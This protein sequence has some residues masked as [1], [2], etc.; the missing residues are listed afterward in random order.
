MVLEAG[1]VGCRDCHESRSALKHNPG[2]DL[3]GGS[4]LGIG[5]L[6]DLFEILPL[7]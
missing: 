3:A 1:W 5:V 6:E 2:G 7:E 4:D